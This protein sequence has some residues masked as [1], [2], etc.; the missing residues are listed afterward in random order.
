MEHSPGSRYGVLWTTLDT[1]PTLDN[2][3]I[4][5]GASRVIDDSSNFGLVHSN[6][7]S[8]RYTDLAPG[9]TTPMHRTSSLDYNVLDGTE[10]HLM[11]GDIVVQKGTMHAWKNP[12]SS[13]WSRLVSVLVAADPA[14]ANGKTLTP[15]FIPLESS[16]SS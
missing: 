16:K 4:E 8:F 1:V 10:R 12:S 5:D 2:R 14:V 11:P 15:H 9:A 6:G 13:V 7:T 3:K